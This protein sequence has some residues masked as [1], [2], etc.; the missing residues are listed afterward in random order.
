MWLFEAML[1]SLVGGVI[2]GIGMRVWDEVTEKMQ[3]RRI[4]EATRVNEI[5]TTATK[6]E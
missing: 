2:L 5:Q 1:I 6:T 4:D 3:A